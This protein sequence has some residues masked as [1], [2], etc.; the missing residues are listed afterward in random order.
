MAATT[1]G[2]AL[3]HAR[4]ADHTTEVDLRQGD[5]RGLSDKT[6]GDLSQIAPRSDGRVDGS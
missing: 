6:L 3:G 4:V 2:V 5:T 1:A